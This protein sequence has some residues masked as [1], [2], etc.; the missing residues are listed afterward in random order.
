MPDI[1]RKV[2][3][4]TVDDQLDYVRVSIARVIFWCFPFLL[5]CIICALGFLFFV[6]AGKLTGSDGKSYLSTIE[7]MA[8]AASI[9]VAIGM[10]MGF[11]SVFIGL[12]MTWFGLSAAFAFSGEAGE[13]RK[14][15]LQSSSPGLLFFLGG[16]ILIGVSLY[17]PIT[18]EDRAPFV[19]PVDI[20]PNP[21]PK[22][23]M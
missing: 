23:S 2:P 19:Q 10:T 12:M 13:N 22:D 4:R 11:V 15:S 9:Q 7:K 20:K 6:I 1:Q 17:K 8:L 16:V 14:L 5:V 18:Y 3:L 21:P